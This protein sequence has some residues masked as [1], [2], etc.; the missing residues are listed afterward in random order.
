MTV[1]TAQRTLTQRAGEAALWQILGGG[2]Q[3]IVRMGASVFL[4]RALKPSD[5]GLFGMA[6]LFQE[7]LLNI[8]ALGMGAGIIA[9]KE[10]SKDD[11]NTCFWTIACVRIFLFLLAF[12]G[13]PLA[14]LFFKEPR[15]VGVVR[16]SSF[17][18]LIHLFG[19]V[20]NILLSK[21]L[22]FKTLNIIN[23]IS[24]LFESF[25]AVFL[26]L[27]TDLAYWS[28]VIAMLVNAIFSNLIIFI[29]VNWVPNFKF[30]KESFHYLFRFG[31]HGLGFSITNYLKQNLDYLLVGRIL[32][33]YQL[34]LYEFA[35]KIPH[36]VVARISRPV[37]AVVFPS[38]AKIQKDNEKIF[39]G[40]VMIVKFVTLIAFPVLFGL[41]ALADILVLVL[42]G[43]QWLPIIRPMQI[44]CLCAALR[45]I[46][47]PLGAIFLCKNRPDIPNITS[48][49]ELIVT[50]I[51]VSIMGYFWNITGIAIGMLLSVLP[52]FIVLYIGFRLIKANIFRFFISIFK[53]FFTALLC[54]IFVWFVKKTLLYLNLNLVTILSL[55]VVSGGIIFLILVLF[56]FKDE[57]FLLKNI[58]FNC[59]L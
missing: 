21:E 51:T 34:G 5:F 59:K 32:G 9:K 10:V 7:F 45:C 48:F 2:W 27:T 42:W 57:L 54:G 16:V 18:F 23:G 15:L 55:S 8:T 20:P 3:T 40:Y 30:D 19:I 33:T 14:A 25:V 4:A 12:L 1:I 41:L 44:L 28:L 11:L 47:Q 49:V 46:V 50:A 29:F 56:F 35:Y 53:T 13:A 39:N 37:G 24:V 22:R 58:L 52:S 26:A 31:I 6:I 36:L 38:L 43:D 17:C